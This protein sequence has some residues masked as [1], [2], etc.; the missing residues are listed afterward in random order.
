MFKAA[1]AET[2][3]RSSGWV[4]RSRSF[5]SSLSGPAQRSKSGGCFPDPTSPKVKLVELDLP[6]SPLPSC[7]KKKA[8]PGVVDDWLLYLRTRVDH[9]GFV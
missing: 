4:E 8:S 1:L 5:A 2:L 7:S 6:Q 3:G 9:T